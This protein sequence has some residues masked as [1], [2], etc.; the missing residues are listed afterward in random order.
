MN[1]SSRQVNVTNA[2]GLHLRAA[3]KFIRLARQFQA[4]VWVVF[5]GRKVHG[6]SILDL[7]T[8]AAACGSRLQVEAGG[9]DADAALDALTDLIKRGFDEQQPEPGPIT[10]MHTAVAEVSACQTPIATAGSPGIGSNI[11]CGPI[12]GL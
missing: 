6:K 9:V 8:L 11:T 12:P 2:L 3:D 5:D 10:P 1:T 4:D 7:T